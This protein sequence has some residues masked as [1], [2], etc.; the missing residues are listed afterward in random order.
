MQLWEYPDEER[1]GFELFPSKAQST[2]DVTSDIA[3]VPFW[4]FVLRLPSNVDE[5]TL[6]QAYDKLFT[7]VQQCH[8]DNGGGVAYNVILVKDWMCLIPRRCSGLEKGAGANAASMVGLVWIVKDS[9]KSVWSA[10]FCRYLG[11]PR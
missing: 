1:M 10:D 4:H 9:E 8:A 5:T 11:I 6:V 2:T 7:K 3:N